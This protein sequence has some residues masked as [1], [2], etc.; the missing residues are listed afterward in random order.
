M[1]RFL[2]VRHGQ[3]A[4]N[5]PER[6]RGRE[7]LP[8]NEYGHRQ[9]EAVARRIAQD[10]PEVAVVYASPL[11]RTMH[12]A[13]AIARV[14]DLTSIPLAG[15][16]D[17]DYGAWQ[18]LS[19]QEVAARYDDLYTAW[20]LAPHTV[21]FPG[22]ESLAD[23]RARVW[24]AVRGLADQHAGE[25]VVLV[26]HQVVNKVLLCA[27]LGLDDAHFWQIEQAT[28]CLNVFEYHEG[29]FVLVLLNDRCHLE[30]QL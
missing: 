11:Q 28:G 29:R 20:Q 8:L 23:V 19:H 21:Q 2:L 14:L 16:L 24:P 26:G 4:W 6:F 12:T 25:T 30:K 13:E 27:V 22:G 15:L 9:A 10:W 3:T 18:G 17:L 7:D 1:T 5:Q